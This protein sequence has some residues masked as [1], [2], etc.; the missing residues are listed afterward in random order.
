MRRIFAYVI[1]AI[2]HF[3]CFR[4]DADSE[5]VF[6]YNQQTPITSLDPAFAKSLNHMWAIE[7]VYNQLLDLDDS[8][9]LVPEIASSWE[10]LD[11]GLTYQFHLRNDIYFQDDTIFKPQSTRLLTAR[12]VKYSFSRLIDKNLATPGSWVFAGK[13]RDSMPFEA[14]SDTIFILHLKQP[15]SPIMQMLTMHYCSI[16]PEEFQKYTSRFVSEHPVGTGPFQLQKWLGKQGMFFKKNENF[17]IEGL[18]KLKGIR[19]SFIEDRTSAYLEFSKGKIDF[20]SGIHSGFASDILDE[21]GDL[22]RS[23]RRS[24]SF[25]KNNFLN[26]EYIGINRTVL[27]PDHCLQNRL[28]R[29]ALNFAIDRAQLIKV[30]RHGIGT[31]AVQGFVPQGMAS[32]DMHLISGCEYNPK[33][34]KALLDSAGYFGL[35]HGAEI[36]IYTNKDYLDI[37][38]FVAGEWQKIGVKCAIELMET[39]ALREQMRVGGVP[40]FRASWV[41]DYPD[42]E[43]FFAPFYS[44]NPAPPNYTRFSSINFDALYD[45]AVT[46]TDYQR[47]MDMYRK[48]DSILISESPVI[49]L[50]YD[51]TAWFASSTIHGLKPNS[52]NILKLCEVYQTVRQQ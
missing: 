14:A 10:I 48:M 44:K 21:N 3:G 22:K 50:F 15:F 43:N 28:V 12:D 5:E 18:P 36:K 25:Y 38:Q 4:P 7:H 52:L 45:K 11:Q 35:Q 40:V 51:Q 31:P 9:K 30:L 19:I 2:L 42:E 47:R 39:S 17:Y 33:K 24:I 26:T 1:L 23:K 13:L 41:A 6:H 20:F 49:F 8:M 27:P 37:I 46:E 32:N 16:V 29:Q 34:A